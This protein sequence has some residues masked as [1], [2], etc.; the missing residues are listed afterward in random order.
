M[1]KFSPVERAALLDMRLVAP[2]LDRDVLHG[3]RHLRAGDVA[4]ADEGGNEVG[5][6]GDEA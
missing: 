5:I 3:K 6:A 4:E 1:A 2:G